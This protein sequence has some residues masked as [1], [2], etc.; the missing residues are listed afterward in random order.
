MGSLNKTRVSCEDK[1]IKMLFT[2]C[3]YLCLYITSAQETYQN[4][5]NIPLDN[6]GLLHDIF[7]TG[8]PDY[9]GELS[10]SSQAVQGQY[11][12]VQ[13]GVSRT[14]WGTSSSCTPA[15]LVQEGLVEMIPAQ[16]MEAPLWSVHHKQDQDSLS[17]QVLCPGAW[18]VDRMGCQGCMLMWRR[19]CAGWTESYFGRSDCAGWVENMKRDKYVG[20]YF[21]GKCGQ[22]Y[23]GSRRQVN[24]GNGY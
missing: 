21:R 18:G 24:K 17:R 5:A 9:D 6:I 8:S 3:L 14:G 4:N 15:L 19:P 22:V 2:F 11:Q 13:P 7:G 1:I 12:G 10:G 16:V 23:G 20:G